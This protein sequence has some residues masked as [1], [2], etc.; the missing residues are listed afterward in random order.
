MIADAPVRLTRRE[1]L[2]VAAAG[3][4][5][6]LLAPAALLH[7]APSGAIE[8][9]VFDAFAIFDPRP[10]ANLAERLFPGRGRELADAWRG[11]QFEYQWL[12]ALSGHYADFQRATEDALL[13]AADLLQLALSEDARRALMGSYLKLTA[14]PDVADALQRLK[15]E[16]LR[17]ALLSN[18][19]PVILHASIANAGLEDM[20]DH[21]LST[22]SQR[23]YK[24]DPRAYRQA[25]DAFRLR[26]DQILF[27]PFAGWDVAGAKSFG[28]RTFWV[29]RM[30]LPPERLGFVA[31][32][33]AR[34]LSNLLA[35]TR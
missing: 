30:G 29:N 7:A 13:F 12:R 4:A 34:D 18:A 31:D 16:G 21:V 15:R 8:A 5:S 33:T 32:A 26:A 23:T 25:L 10:I 22:D 28:Y 3:T 2:G 27:V 6:G 9:V 14:W 19:T 11:R 35:Y 17:S 24:P 1:I 20:F